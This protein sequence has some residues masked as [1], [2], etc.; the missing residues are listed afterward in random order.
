MSSAD[1][2]RLAVFRR[3]LDELLAVDGER[4][5]PEVVI[6]LRYHIALVML[7]ENEHV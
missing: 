5:Y 3:E 1:M 6:Y 2:V 7:K 4:R